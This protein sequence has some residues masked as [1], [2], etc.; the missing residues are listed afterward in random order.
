MNSNRIFFVTTTYPGQGLGHLKRCLSLARSLG[1]TVWSPEP[2]PLNL[3]PEEGRGTFQVVS[4]SLP[5]LHGFDLILVDRRKTSG[6]LFRQLKASGLPIIGLDEGGRERKNFSFLVDILHNTCRHAPNLRV[7]GWGLR[8]QAGGPSSRRKGVLVSFGGEDSGDLTGTF[9]TFWKAHNPFP[10]PVTV[11]IGPGFQK[12]GPYEGWTV[13]SNVE[14]LAGVLPDYETV[15][16]TY[17]LTSW[18]ALSAG[19][20]VVNLNPTRYHEKLSQKAG[21]PSLGVKKPKTSRFRS[22][23]TTR[24]LHQPVLPPPTEW[25]SGS[26]EDFLRNLNHSPDECPVCHSRERKILFRGPQKT[27]GTCRECSMG[28]LTTWNLPQKIYTEDYFEIEYKNQYGRTYLE[29]FDH[30]KA[31]GKSRLG[32]IKKL[33]P[34]GPLLDAG[35]AYGP[36]LAAAQEAGFSPY[37]IDVAREAVA[38]V[39]TSLGYPAKVLSLTDLNWSQDF[40]GAGGLKV[41]TLWYVIE[42]FSDLNP[43]L[44]ALNENL[45]F[46]G[47]LAFSTPN[48]R[49]I[50]GL[51]SPKKFFR[52]SPDDHFSLWTPRIARKVLKRYGFRVQKIRV[53]GHHPERFPGL[54]S[55]SRFIKFVDLCSRLWGWGDT[56]E[57]YARKERPL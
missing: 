19:C 40:P 22:L 13:L 5:A 26:L 18:E 7:P 3:P 12:K 43:V 50:T 14:N 10:D 4:G 47:T 2:W 56:F 17:G 15:I 33:T 41:L 24:H 20:A 37:G 51:F 8:P 39:Q 1:G 27:Y 21:F 25:P 9:Y 46:R 32:V 53:T 11:V 49:G 16:T 45:D 55:Q 36:F 54:H 30:I 28:S 44:R 42:H 52:E 29:D 57:V 35:C 34:A 6:K 38:H 48:A 31:M 23:W